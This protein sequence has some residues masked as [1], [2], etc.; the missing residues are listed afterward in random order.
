VSTSG[1]DL[2]GS[3]HRRL[4]PLTG[5]YVLVSPRRA[6]RPWQGQSETPD[7]APARSY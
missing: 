7:A 5:D 6:E 1:F 2:Q 4:N 3:V